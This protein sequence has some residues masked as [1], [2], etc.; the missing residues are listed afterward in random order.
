MRTASINSHVPG[1]VLG[2]TDGAKVISGHHGG[3][4]RLGFVDF[5]NVVSLTLGGVRCLVGSVSIGFVVALISFHVANIAFTGARLPLLYLR[6]R[7]TNTQTNILLSGE[8]KW[9]S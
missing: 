3:I 1:L 9:F 4:C 6:A 7:N 5:A 2:L 8:K